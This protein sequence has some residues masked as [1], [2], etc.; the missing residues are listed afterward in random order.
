MSEGMCGITRRYRRRI[1]AG[2][3][4]STACV[5]DNEILDID[6]SALDEQ[7][8]QGEMSLRRSVLEHLTIDPKRELVF[9]LK[10]LSIVHE[11]ERIGDL[12][13]SLEKTGRLAKKPRMGKRV[14]PLRDM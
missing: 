1:L 13:K 12:T 2:N 3:A 14:K 6:L 10:L 9:S 5:L 7:I 4:A 11:A 8:N